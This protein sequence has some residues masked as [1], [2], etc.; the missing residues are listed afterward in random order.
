MFPEGVTMGKEDSSRHVC[1]LTVGTC[2]LECSVYTVSPD[3][4]S[5]PHEEEIIQS[6]GSVDG[7]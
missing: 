5:H 3:T 4:H 1:V 6:G 7:L 2:C